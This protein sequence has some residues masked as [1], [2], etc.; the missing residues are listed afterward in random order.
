M[1]GDMS[2]WKTQ[3]KISTIQ[4]IKLNKDNNYT[5]GISNSI[6][7]N[8][9]INKAVPIISRMLMYQYQNG[10]DLKVKQ[11]D[12][13]IKT[14]LFSDRADITTQFIKNATEGGGDYEEY[15]YELNYSIPLETKFIEI[16]A[17]LPLWTYWVKRGGNVTIQIQ[18]DGRVISTI[19]HTEK[20]NTFNLGG[21]FPEITYDN[22][23]YD[24]SIQLPEG[25]SG[26][27]KIQPI[28]SQGTS[29][30]I[31]KFTLFMGGGGNFIHTTCY[32]QK[33]NLKHELDYEVELLYLN[34]V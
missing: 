6:S 31:S 7:K 20:V 14:E 26:K 18:L 30:G 24:S 23:L 1:K 9:N 17:I 15:L 21:E 25:H 28:S 34:E 16:L 33:Y 5:A 22:F 32:T 27:L 10:F 4:T 3:N 13:K 19:K 29:G 8:F 2:M 11:E 12:N